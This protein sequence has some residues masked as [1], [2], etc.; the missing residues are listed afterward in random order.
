MTRTKNELTIELAQYNNKQRWA[1]IAK[2]CVLGKNLVEETGSD[3]GND[4]ANSRVF[5][6]NL[7]YCWISTIT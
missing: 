3:S 1:S 7:Y 2:L 5:R 4:S 6:S